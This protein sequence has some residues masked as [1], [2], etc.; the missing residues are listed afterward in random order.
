VQ[1]RTATEFTESWEAFMRAARR[2]R[3][4]DAQRS[5]EDLSVAQFQ[6]LEPLLTGPRPVRELREAA[7]V[8]YPTATRAL[9]A[10]VEKGIVRRSADASDKRLVVVELTDAGRGRVTGK[11]EQVRAARRRIAAQL[12]EDELVQ[13]AALLRRL[14][15][16]VED[17]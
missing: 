17:L 10:L 12:T 14:A 16:A 7:G 5:G 8:S 3:G 15:E 6:L 4:R 2:A 11:E 9:D 13:G 1:T